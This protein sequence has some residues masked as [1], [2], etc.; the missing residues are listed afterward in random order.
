V[1]RPITVFTVGTRKVQALPLS[2]YSL[3]TLFYDGAPKKMNKQQKGLLKRAVGKARAADKPKR[4]AKVPATGN[5]YFSRLEPGAARKLFDETFGL[6]PEA[7]K[8]AGTGEGKFKQRKEPIPA[9]VSYSR[10]GSLSAGAGGMQFVKM[11]GDT[12]EM[13]CRIYVGLV[14]SDPTTA[15]IT[16]LYAAGVTGTLLPE[17]GCTRISPSA[18]SGDM[19]GIFPIQAGQVDTTTG[20]EAYYRAQYFNPASMMTSVMSGYYE[21]WRPKYIK[22][23]YTPVCPTSV[24]GT[25]AIAFSPQDLSEFRNSTTTLSAYNNTFIVM[26][27]CPA[28]VE[29]PLYKD[30]TMIAYPCSH[31]IA[32]DGRGW[33]RTKLVESSQTSVNS[34][35]T[36]QT[37]G[38]VLL[39]NASN[40]SSAASTP[41]G[42]VFYEVCYEFK[43]TRQKPI[44]SFGYQALPPAGTPVGTLCHPTWVRHPLAGHP[45]ESKT[46][47]SDIEMVSNS[48]R[49]RSLSRLSLRSQ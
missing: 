24:Q 17:T 11:H 21:F 32:S 37:F 25:L 27:Q 42:H 5:P 44:N 28:F 41:F 38:G 30:I 39:M 34:T 14:Q 31:G 43:G 10:S 20:Q 49:I 13:C 40:T 26:S 22:V 18:A 35:L 12:M 46:D 1:A 47:D 7:A 15:T 2:V 4:Q 8:G 19:Y 9:A 16:N 29:A 45:V 6:K 23:C 3:V 36:T 33:L 48:S